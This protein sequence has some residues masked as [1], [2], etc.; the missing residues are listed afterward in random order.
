[1]QNAVHSMECGMAVVLGT[2][3]DKVRNLLQEVS[4]HG[5]CDI[6]NDNT[7]DQVVI[8]GHKIA[9][10]M[11]IKLAAKYGAKRVLPISVSAPFHSRLMK[12]AAAIMEDA[13]KSVTIC[14]PVTGFIPNILAHLENESTLYKN[15]LVSQ[16]T[17]TVRWRESIEYMYKV[18]G[19][20]K[21]V[22]FGPGKTLSNMI[23]RSYPDSELFTILT[24]KDIEYYASYVSK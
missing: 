24:P 2:D 19:I 16:V 11:A 5:I 9:I 1:M 13:L 10:D 20:R 23:K 15:L 8:S 7:D 3:L 12:P 21:F 17:D 6:A 4:P 18:L 14:N 22:E